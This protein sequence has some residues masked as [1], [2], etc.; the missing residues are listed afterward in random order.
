MAVIG[1]I[2]YSLTLPKIYTS[3]T[4]LL[5]PQQESTMG[6]GLLSQLSGGLGGLAGGFLGVSAPAD[7][8]LAILKSQTIKDAIIQRFDLMK[9]FE[10]QNM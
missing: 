4:T 10:A 9:I 1:S 7:L 3:T 8:W 6:S 2:I 5:P